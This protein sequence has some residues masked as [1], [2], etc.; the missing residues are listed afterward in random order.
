MGCNPHSGAILTLTLVQPSPPVHFDPSSGATLTTQAF[1]SILW[2]N[3][4]HPFISIHPLVQ[5]SPPGPFDPSSGATPPSVPPRAGVL[6]Q[7]VPQSPAVLVGP[8]QRTQPQPST[9]GAA[10]R[11]LAGRRQMLPDRLRE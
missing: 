10:I 9:E 8:L 6:V 2:C 4:H 7:L 1:R 11:A 3:P 5:P